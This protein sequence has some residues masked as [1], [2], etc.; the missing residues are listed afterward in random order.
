MEWRRRD[1][2][3]QRLTV[4]RIAQPQPAAAVTDDCAALAS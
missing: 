1:G 2:S 3:V 4:Q